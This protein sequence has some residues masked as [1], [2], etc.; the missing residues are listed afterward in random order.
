M[1]FAYPLDF[2]VLLTQGTSLV[3]FDP[4]RHTAQVK[5]V[6][7]L[8]PHNNT[9]ILLVLR[10]T[11]QACIH[12]LYPANSTCIT[13]NIPTPHCNKIPFLKGEHF[14]CLFSTFSVWFSF[15]FHFIRHLWV[16]LPHCQCSCFLDLTPTP[17]LCHPFLFYSGQDLGVLFPSSVVGERAP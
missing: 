13:F 2:P 14:I 16:C 17:S 6:V 8:S 11:S 7:T 15:N 12:H 1:S 3:L 5:R 10:L 4:Q 9:V